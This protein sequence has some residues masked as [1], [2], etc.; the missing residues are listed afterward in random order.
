M[1]RLTDFFF[2]LPR[3]YFWAAVAVIAVL[4]LALEAA[5]LVLAWDYALV[6][7]VEHFG[8]AVATMPFTVA[9]R[10]MIVATLIR[11]FVRRGHLVPFTFSFSERTTY[12]YP[13]EPRPPMPTGAI[14]IP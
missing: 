5:A 6:P 4:V 2:D 13:D 10:V 1:R 8:G 14:P 11:Q 9:V 12:G 3:P 7:I